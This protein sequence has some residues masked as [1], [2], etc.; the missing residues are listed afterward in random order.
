MDLII[1]A[2]ALFSVLIKKSRSEE[3]LFRSEVHLF[4]PEFL[5]EEFRKYETTIIG[6]TSRNVGDF[7]NL[8]DILKKRITV[9]PNEETQD[10]MEEAR[11]LSP[12]QNDADYF[13][14]ALKMRA[15][16]WSNDKVLKEKQNAI[17]VYS[18]Y[19]LMKIL[20]M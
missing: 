20:R 15:A 11:A 5:F 2:N 8:L 3:I 16:I 17:E 7:Y 13:A 14:L 10:C 18:T 1:D 12:D 6:K 19:E 9:I 4:A